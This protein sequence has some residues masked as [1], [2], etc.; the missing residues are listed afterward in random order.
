VCFNVVAPRYQQHLVGLSVVPEYQAL[1]RFNAV[2]VMDPTL[3]QPVDKGK[4][5]AR[6]DGPAPAPPAAAAPAS[7]AAA[8][9][10]AAP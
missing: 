6:E 2:A 5:R 3:L 4:K 1:C 9:P 10:T 8:A 7:P